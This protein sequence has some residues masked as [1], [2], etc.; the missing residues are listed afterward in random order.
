MQPLRDVMVQLVVPQQQLML[1]FSI[2]VLVSV[3]PK[4]QFLALEVHKVIQDKLH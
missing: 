2:M 1:V 3:L 4:L